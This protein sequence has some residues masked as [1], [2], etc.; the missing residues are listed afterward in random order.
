L[1]KV[2]EELVSGMRLY[3]SSWEVGLSLQYLNF[4]QKV[5]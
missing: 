5:L 4:P 2:T 3:P 1:M